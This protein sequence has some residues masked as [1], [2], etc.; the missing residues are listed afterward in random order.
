MLGAAGCAGARRRPSSPS[1]SRPG[2]AS[3][4]EARARAA[5]GSTRASAWAALEL[6]GVTVACGNCHGE[7]GRGRAEGGVVP[8]SIQWSEL[9]K[10]YGHDHDERSPHGPFDDTQPATCGHGGFR[11]DGNRLDGAMP[12]FS[13]SAK[14]FAALAAYLK[15][16]EVA[17]RPRPGRRDDPHRHAAADVRSPGRRWAS[18][19]ARC[20]APYFASLN[21]HGGIHGRRLELVVEAAAERRRG[22]RARRAR[23]H[24]ARAARYSRCSRRCRPG[25]EAG[26]VG[27]GRRAA[28]AGDRTADAASRKTRGPPTRTSS[29]CCRASSNWRRC[30]RGTRRGSCSSRERPIALWHPDTRGRPARTAQAVEAHA[31][32]GGLARA[33]SGALPAARVIARRAG[34]HAARRAR[35]RRRAGARRRRRRRRPGGAPARASAGRRTC[36]CPGRWRSRDIVDAAGGVPRPRDAGLSDLAGRPARRRRCASTR[37]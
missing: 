35:L 19:C 7:D 33:A 12:R 21:E 27:R 34:G 8:P 30:W 28:G 5:R 31:A 17:A 6:S 18:R 11:P 24:A 10:P 22:R 26:T 25:V 14:D 3:T 37:R 4:C 15:K 23:A 36:W 13:M 9:T 32:R 1:R 29:T 20:W 16:L 2:S